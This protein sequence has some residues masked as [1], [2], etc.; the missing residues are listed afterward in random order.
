VYHFE[1]TTGYEHANP[2]ILKMASQILSIIVLFAIA[3]IMIPLAQAASP[4]EIELTSVGNTQVDLAWEKSERMISTWTSVSNY[5]KN[6]KSFTMQIVQTET[7]NVVAETPI[8]VITNS[9]SSS[10]D[11]NLFIKYRVN[12]EDICQ[13]EEYNASEPALQECNPLTGAYEMQ[14]SADD[15]SVVES[16][17][18]TIV[19]TRE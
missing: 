19:D 12:A 1:Q 15:G 13:N 17:T 16:T 18:F 14:V 3:T 2:N 10:I 7:G 9:Q 11:F 6:D 8:S 4:T 5:D